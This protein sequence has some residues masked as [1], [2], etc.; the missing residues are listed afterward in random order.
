MKK[1]GF[2]LVELLVVIAIIGVLIALLLPA[3]QAAREA[4]R[5][6][7]CNNNLRQMGLAMHNHES[8]KRRFPSGG[9]GTFFPDDFPASPAFTNFDVHSFFAYILPFVEQGNI[10]QQ[11]DFRVPYLATVE[12]LAAARIAV[13]IYTC[14]SDNYRIDVTDTDGFG[15]VDYGPTCYTDIDPVTGLKNNAA[16][17]D[18]ALIV[19]GTDGR[20]ISDGTSNTIAVAEDA[21]R[22]QSMIANT[23]YTYDAPGESYD[24]ELRKLWRWAEPDNAFGVTMGV[25]RNATPIDGPP[26]CPWARNNCGPND[27]IFAFHPGG[28]NVVYCDGHVEFLT[29]AIAATALRRLVSRA[30]DEL[31]ED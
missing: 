31:I 8:S 26:D 23:T 27:E 13:T 6:S 14:P 10:Q 7:Q 9:Q 24:G 16:R 29:D 22:N 3:I 15:T 20:E 25:N 5:R 30:G 17:V 4:A 18:G 2:T 12:N 21:G 1:R 11:I 19:G 28:A